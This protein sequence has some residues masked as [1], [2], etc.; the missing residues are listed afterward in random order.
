[1]R[2]ALHQLTLSLALP[3]AVGAV[4]IARAERV[5]PPARESATAYQVELAE[6]P[7]PIRE[8]LRTPGFATEV[9]VARR[10]P[11]DSVS[12]R[13]RP[14]LEGSPGLAPSPV[15]LAVGA[16][17]KRDF[18]ASPSLRGA[19]QEALS[20][21]P[22]A[23]PAAL[24][25][26]PPIALAAPSFSSRR[27]MAPAEMVPPAASESA[28]PTQTGKPVAVAPAVDADPSPWKQDVS[29]RA[30]LM[31]MQA[32][33]SAARYDPEPLRGRGVGA[34]A[35]PVAATRHVGK[36][37]PIA[38][39]DV[40][41]PS[42]IAAGDVGK[43]LS[44]ATGDAGKPPSIATGPVRIDR[45][46]PEKF[47]HADGHAPLLPPGLI[48]D[49][50]SL[51]PLSRVP[52]FLPVDLPLVALQNAKR[53]APIDRVSDFSVSPPIPSWIGLRPTL[54][55]LIPEPGSAILLGASLAALGASRRSRRRA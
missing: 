13:K 49:R 7:L 54:F 31:P 37:S 6:L 34:G 4:W 36:P 3:I 20:A 24:R 9:P 16:G 39:G 30:P 25:G 40:G 55:V 15:D 23:P 27:G 5:E 8:R 44:I 26:A 12:P 17:S 28:A 42:P 14:V 48:E 18:V 33:L 29:K 46:P 50:L 47:A 2:E 45:S 21:L 35:G 52:S 51:Q 53:E 11:E 1:M 38:A 32:A 43:P 10:A 41:K 19:A 22:P